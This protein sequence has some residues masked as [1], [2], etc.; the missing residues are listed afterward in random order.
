[1]TATGTSNDAPSIQ[2]GNTWGTYGTAEDTVL[3]NNRGSTKDNTVSSKPTKST[4]ID[5][6]TDKYDEYGSFGTSANTAMLKAR[7]RRSTSHTKSVDK[8]EETV[9]EKDGISSLFNFIFCLGKGDGVTEERDSADN[10]KRGNKNVSEGRARESPGG[11]RKSR[12]NLN[13]NADALILEQALKDSKKQ[14]SIRGKAVRVSPSDKL[15]SL[16]IVMELQQ[17]ERTTVGRNSRSPKKSK[18]Q[19]VLGDKSVMTDVFDF[20]GGSKK[21]TFPSPLPSTNLCMHGPMLGTFQNISSKDNALHPEVVNTYTTHRCDPRSVDMILSRIKCSIPLYH[22]ENSAVSR[23]NSGLSAASSDNDVAKVSNK[24]KHVCSEPVS[25]TFQ[26]RS[27]T[28]LEDG[29]K[30]P[31]DESIFAL[32]GVDSIVKQKGDTNYRDCDVSKSPDSYFNRLWS[33]NKRLGLKTPFLTIINFVV[34]WGN[35]VGYFYRPDG[36]HGRPYNASRKNA[37]TPSEKLWDKFLQGDE[38]YRNSI[39][40]FIPNVVE[41]PWAL[42]KLV[43]SQ[44]VMIGQK[45]PTTYYGSLDD[46]Y[47]EICMNVTKGGKMANSICSAVASKASI[48]SIDL[49]FLLQGDDGQELPEQVLSVMRLHHVRL[50]KVS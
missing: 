47:L 28:Y 30:V 49:A 41:G 14:E 43:G 31:S 11:G 50:K 34:P 13:D 24:I 27:S 22:D 10:S 48:V 2:S 20:G 1:M 16:D 21:F 18:S 39:L 38:T 17:Q 29:K 5:A 35:L 33:A 8:D 9:Q 37:N 19:A 44:P 26:V 6:P 7:M 46:G 40:K 36:E 3:M 23:A 15:E 32:L 45:I 42:K 4:S 12:R 25:K